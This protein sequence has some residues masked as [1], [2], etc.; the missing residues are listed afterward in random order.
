MITLSMTTSSIVVPP[1]APGLALQLNGPAGA[2]LQRV[3]V[4]WQEECPAIS[5]SVNASNVAWVVTTQAQ[6]LALNA[7][8]GETLDVAVEVTGEP[9]AYQVTGFDFSVQG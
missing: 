3:C 8:L 2:D 1:T 9:G 5:G 4:R 6:F 7:C